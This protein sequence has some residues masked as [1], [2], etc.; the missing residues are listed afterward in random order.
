LVLRTSKLLA[1][2]HL[3]RNNPAALIIV[4]YAKRQHIK[5]MQTYKDKKNTNAQ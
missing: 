1:E 4:Y 2:G 5:Y 3:P